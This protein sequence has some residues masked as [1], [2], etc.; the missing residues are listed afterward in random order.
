MYEK[1]QCTRKK[2]ISL[3][4]V[5]SLTTRVGPASA[6]QLF[7]FLPSGFIQPHFPQSSSRRWWFLSGG[8]S[9]SATRSCPPCTV[10]DDGCQ[11]PARQERRVCVSVSAPWFGV[12][13]AEPVQ[14][15]FGVKIAWNTRILC[16]LIRVTSLSLVNTIT[17]K[18]IEANEWLCAVNGMW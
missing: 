13:P 2:I 3:C 1:Q 10:T 16:T 7:W 5:S 18:I 6:F 17:L 8:W 12:P 4:P 15:K 9:H 14:M 11:A